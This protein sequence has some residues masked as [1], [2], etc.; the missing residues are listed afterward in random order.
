[1]LQNRNKKVIEQKARGLIRKNPETS[2]ESVRQ[3]GLT[4]LSKG[5]IRKPDPEILLATSMDGEGLDLA[6]N[7]M[8]ES[9]LSGKKD[10]ASQKLALLRLLLAYLR[11][12]HWLHWTSHWQVKG[13]T[14]YGDHLLFERLYTGIVEEIDTLAEKVVGE[15][16]AEAVNPLEQSYFLLGLVNDVAKMED[17]AIKRGLVVEQTM[18]NIL[19]RVYNKLKSIDALTLGLDDFLMATANA[20]DTYL[21]LLKQRL[22]KK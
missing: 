7:Q 10:K 17:N 14:S 6:F 22:S 5:E 15:F 13:D 16:G 4:K 12:T 20:H 19:K 1:M 9:Y 18:Q 8:Q 2:F 21:Y 11:A 3:S